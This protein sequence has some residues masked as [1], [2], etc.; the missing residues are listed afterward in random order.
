M[1]SNYAV[2]RDVSNP[3]VSKQSFSQIANKPAVIIKPK[4]KQACEETR[5]VVRENI[6]PLELS[7]GVTS[8]KTVKNGG[9]SSEMSER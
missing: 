3:V 5:R 8:V 4:D 6:K 1:L 7:V 9:N 2:N